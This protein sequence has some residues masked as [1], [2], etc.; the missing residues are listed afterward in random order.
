MEFGE[1]QELQGAILGNC[2]QSL[3]SRQ[4]KEE[5]S[6]ASHSQQDSD[7]VYQAEQQKEGFFQRRTLLMHCLI[8]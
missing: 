3:Y 1:E 8:W 2:Q 5:N 7:P 6:E 4:T